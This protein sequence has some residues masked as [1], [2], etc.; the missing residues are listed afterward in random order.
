MKI[1]LPVQQHTKR[2]RTPATAKQ[3]LNNYQAAAKKAGEMHR[4][5]VGSMMDIFEKTNAFDKQ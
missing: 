3:D 4:V 5:F 1:R 2:V